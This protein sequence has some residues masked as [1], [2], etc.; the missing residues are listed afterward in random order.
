[1]V[2][3]WKKKKPEEAPQPEPAPEKPQPPT[4]TGG[5]TRDAKRPEGVELADEPKERAGWFA[6][7]TAGIA[8][9][10]ANFTGQ[11]AS[12]F[13]DSPKIDDEFYENL[14]HILLAADCGVEITQEIVTMIKHRAGSD[15][16]FNAEKGMAAIKETIRSKV[17]RNTGPMNLNKDPFSVILIVGVNGVGKTTTIA[18]LSNILKAYGQKMM[19]IAGDTFRA[20]AIE[21]LGVWGERLGIDVHKG[22]AG[23]DPSAVIFDGL[24]AAKARK[25]DLVVIDTA[26]R[27]H[28]Q[29]N[30][31]EEIRKV[32][33]VIQK[34][35]PEAPHETWLV[36]DATTGQ[37]AINQAA[38]FDKALSLT[39]LVLTKLDGTA[40]GGIVVAISQKLG[41]PIRFVGVGEGIDDLNAF[42][43][44]EF[45]D[46][47]FGDAKG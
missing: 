41:L 4:T 15:P 3:W 9:S 44:E 39:G 13:K 35:L 34:V 45:V 10:R 26:G 24:N 14:E 40:K 30:L 18:K 29:V 8:R 32:R 21:Q 28:T 19:L 27:L 20:G 17:A 1:M 36:L 43:P 31:M 5:A 22:Q 11:I 2:L 47:L 38:L 16:T 33:R 6:R 23:A 46:A 42:K 37:N 12:L 25:V 7:L